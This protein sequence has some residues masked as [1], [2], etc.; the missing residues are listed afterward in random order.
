MLIEY[1]KAPIS[2]DHQI[3]LLHERGL[4]GA[5]DYLRGIL[6]SV[7]YYRFTGYL[8]HFKRPQGESFCEGLRAEDVWKLYTFDRALRAYTM[9]AIGRI[10]VWLRAQLACLATTL[11]KDAFDYVSCWQADRT[12]K[13]RK[14]CEQDL[15]HAEQVLHIKHFNNTYS[16]PY[17]PTWMAI[18]VFSFGTTC[19]Y[20]TYCDKRVAGTIARRLSI[21]RLTLLNWL[22]LLRATRNICAHHQRLWD[23]NINTQPNLSSLLARPDLPLTLPILSLYAANPKLTFTVN[24]NPIRRTPVYVPLAICAQML[25]VFRPQSQWKK[26]LLNL[27]T[28]NNDLLNHILPDYTNGEITLIGFENNIHSQYPLWHI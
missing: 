26:R 11:S 20:L 1:S 23:V 2:L 4:L 24:N 3:A 7:G 28:T 21:D 14:A 22:Q 13:F 25:S 18:D 10:E 17:P 19:Q 6:E 12:G 15:K 9:E 5:D 27:I 16:Q 8:H